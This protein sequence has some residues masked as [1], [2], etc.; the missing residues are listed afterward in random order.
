MCFFWLPA[1]PPL[2]PHLYAH[3]CPHLCLCAHTAEDFNRKYGHDYRYVAKVEQMVWRHYKA[4]VH[5]KCASV[6]AYCYNLLLLL[7]LLRQLR[8]QIPVAVVVAALTDAHY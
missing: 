6:S 4:Q 8:L 2:C 3:T 5:D 7:L 1:R